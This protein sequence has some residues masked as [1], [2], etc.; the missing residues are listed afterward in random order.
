MRPAGHETGPT[1]ARNRADAAT[2]TDV[3]GLIVVLLAVAMCV[4]HLYTAAFGTMLA[5]Y[6][7]A[8]HWVFIS[9]LVFLTY[10]IGK[11]K[12]SNLLGAVD[13]LLIGATVV[14][15]A[16]LLVFYDDILL[17]LGVPTTADV[18]LGTITMLIVLE[19]ARRTLGWALPILAMIMLAYAYLGPY[20]PGLLA[21]RGYPLSRVASQM[22]LTTEGIFGMAIGVS[23]TFIVVFVAFGSFLEKSGAGKFFV[24]IANAAMGHVAGG[25]AQAAVWSSALMGTISGSPVANVVTTGTFTIPLMKKT[26][27][28]P[29]YAGAVEA[30]ASSGGQ[31]MPPIMGVGAFLMAE[32]IGVPYATI[33]KAAIIPA[34]LYFLTLGIAVY[35][36]ARRLGL[37][38]TP[39]SELPSVWRTLVAGIPYLIPLAILI[40]LLA[41]GYSPL[42]SAF[43]AIVAIAVLAAFGLT[44]R[45]GIREIIQAMNSTAKSVA[46][47]ATACACA[48]IIIG[49]TTLTGLGLKLSTLVVEWSHGLTFV[50]LVLTMLVSLVLGMGLPTS[51]AYLV[52]AVL[53]GPALEKM[54]VPILAAHLF[55]FY[56]GC[57][58][59]ITPPVALAAYAA[60][61]IAGSDPMR[62]GW[63]ASRLGIASFIVPYMFVYGPPLLLQGKLAE[64]MLSVPTALIGGFFLATGA[65]GWWGRPLSPAVRLLLGG[66]ALLLIK[67]GLGTDIAGLVIGGVT[68]L[69]LTRVNRR[70]GRD[71]SVTS[72]ASSACG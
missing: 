51:A 21:H 54:G 17:R 52:L 47:V 13:L 11:G 59:T 4:F 72:G 23:A 25:P 24:D 69:M 2:R 50:G 31:I 28:E 3:R 19:T 70:C 42:K 1:Q 41:S 12:R 36:E 67:P 62:T 9:V 5:M 49:V 26:G 30:V 64:I 20:L 16:Y 43:F 53:G 61:G 56:F 58:S 34:V 29:H 40:Y 65:A 44:D 57:I 10:P 71:G 33:A 45:M 18:V 63:T 6:Q 22:Y 60:A 37:K 48:G 27:Y 8:V 66:A 15:G 46:P 35:L 7:R 32:L 14:A 39:R 38:G 68:L 55:I